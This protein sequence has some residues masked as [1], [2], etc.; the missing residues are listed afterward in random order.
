LIKIEVGIP[1]SS[2]GLTIA[3]FDEYGIPTSI[4]INQHCQ[5]RVVKYSLDNLQFTELVSAFDGYRLNSPNDLVVN[6][7][8]TTLYFTDPIYGFLEKT[9]FYDAPYLDEKRDLPFCGVYMVDLAS[10][11]IQI[12]DKM[13]RPN[14]IGIHEDQLVV[15]ECCQGEH[16]PKCKQGDARWK[17]YRIGSQNEP[18]KFEKEI[19]IQLEG[20]G[21]ADGFKIL[22]TGTI[23]AS[24]PGGLCLIEL[25]TGQLMA[26]LKSKSKYS[27]VEIAEGY[28]YVT[29]EQSVWRIKLQEPETKQVESPKSDL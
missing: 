5:R 1:Y 3:E 19:N 16:N 7:E 9:R 26:Q 12:V 27:N 8:R 15:S 29:G 21:C 18:P 14:G 11:K 4:F 25:K 23:V 28:A 10:S 22:P 24:C 13:D 2:N 17:V 20:R 6:K